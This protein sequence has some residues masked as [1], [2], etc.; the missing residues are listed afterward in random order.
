MNWVEI[1]GY[2][3]EHIISNL[4][5]KMGLEVENTTLSADG[6]I[7]IIAY[8]NAPILKSK[9]IIQCKNWVN[10]IGEPVIRDL[11]G[12]VMS[13]KANKGIL[14]CTSKFTKQA[15][16]FADINNIEII[17]NDILT[18]LLVDNQIKI[19]IPNKYALTFDGLGESILEKIHFYQNQIIK[20]KS[21]ENNYDK[22]RIIYLKG[23]IKTKD[24][25][26]S[27]LI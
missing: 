21:N 26:N 25:L 10:S 16:K 18:K 6:G 20:D 3:F 22:L 9:Y 2:E 1:S 19:D 13:E 14:I 11:Y 5:S 15:I 4:M 7:D 24:Q 12:V 23:L 17:D 27:K 8:N